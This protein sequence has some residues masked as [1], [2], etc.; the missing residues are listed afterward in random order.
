[1]YFLFADIRG[2]PLMKVEGLNSALALAWNCDYAIVHEADYQEKA[3]EKA[4]V[5]TESLHCS[6]CRTAATEVPLTAHYG[7]S[8]TAWLCPQCEA[9]NEEAE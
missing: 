7:L 8:K 9:E 3:P 5:M 2:K 1:M 6:G 4:P